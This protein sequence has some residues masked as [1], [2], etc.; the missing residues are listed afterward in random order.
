MFLKQRKIIRKVG[1]DELYKLIDLDVYHPD[2]KEYDRKTDLL[3]LKGLLSDKMLVY[4]DANLKIGCIRSVSS[5]W[6]QAT[7]KLYLGNKSAEKPVEGIVFS[8][9]IQFINIGDEDSQ[10]FTVEPN[11]QL[12]VKIY[13]GSQ[14]HR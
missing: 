5:E 3:Y 6:R 14:V 8:K 13:V 2:L 12:E 10:P 1:T 7:L 11:D 9:D 4:D